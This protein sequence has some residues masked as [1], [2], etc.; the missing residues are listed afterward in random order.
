MDP[1][2]EQRLLQARRQFLGQSGV[3]IGMAA[4]A[5]LM[6]GDVRG[7]RDLG[8]DVDFLAQQHGQLVLQP[9]QGEQT[10][11]PHV[12]IDKEI[13]V[14][15]GLV[16]PTRDRPEDPDVLGP[17][18]VGRPTDALPVLA[19]LHHPRSAHVKATR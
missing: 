12:E 5:S 13:Y 9:G 17:M 2:I 3:S 18:P 4:L 14:G 1:R 19:Q 7:E 11:G 8:D 15:V 16:R 6:G 10:P